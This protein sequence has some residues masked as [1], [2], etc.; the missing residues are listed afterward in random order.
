[1]ALEMA[2]KD[3]ACRLKDGHIVLEKEL[4]VDLIKS[5]NQI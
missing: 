3:F 1:V 5:S 2:V 4:Y